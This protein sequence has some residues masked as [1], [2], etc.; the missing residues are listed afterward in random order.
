MNTQYVLHNHFYSWKLG[1]YCRYLAGLLAFLRLN[2]FPS[3]DS[4]LRIFNQYNEEL[5]LQ[6]QPRIFTGFP[7]IGVWKYSNYQIRQ[8][9]Y[10]IFFND[11]KN[12]QN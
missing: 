3:N 6:E 5:Q 8:Q 1:V 2:A 4:G 10:V 11:E 7:F 9:M 12:Y